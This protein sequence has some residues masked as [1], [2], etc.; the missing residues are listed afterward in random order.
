MDQLVVAATTGGHGESAGQG[1]VDGAKRRRKAAEKRQQA[2][3]YRM[4]SRL[5]D[6]LTR[7]FARFRF[8][9]AVEQIRQVAH[10]VME[11]GK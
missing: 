2:A 3:F 10:R 9:A 1:N 5:H 8:Q 6:T 4:E 11:L 7:E